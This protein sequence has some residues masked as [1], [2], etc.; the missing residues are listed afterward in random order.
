MIEA[1]MV[2][3]LPVHCVCPEVAVQRA[4]ITLRVVQFANSRAR[5]E[6]LPTARRD[7]TCFDQ[8]NAHRTDH[9]DRTHVDRTT[10]NVP[11][12]HMHRAMRDARCAIISRWRRGARRPRGSTARAP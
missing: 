9:V 1:L 11:A 7:Y 10:C 2:A 3:I 4:V 12:Q 8:R 5:L 6:R